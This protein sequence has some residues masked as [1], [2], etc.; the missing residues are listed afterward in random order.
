MAKTISNEWLVEA[1]KELLDDH[2]RFPEEVA[3]TPDRYDE[4]KGVLFS[5]PDLLP[6]APPEGEPG[7]VGT[8][9]IIRMCNEAG[10]RMS[11]TNPHRHLIWLCATAI[12]QLVDR[13]EVFENPASGR[14]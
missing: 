11:V 3:M 13:L 1:C 14:M 2:G 5:D 10:A 12:R 7:T 8:S 9:D 6:K 4:I